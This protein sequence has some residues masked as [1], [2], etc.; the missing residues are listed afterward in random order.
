ME[1]QIS[2]ECVVKLSYTKFNYN[3]FGISRAFIRRR[4][5]RAAL[6]D[7]LRWRLQAKGT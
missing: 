7:T 3:P 5:R 2:R 1:T 4:P 6:K